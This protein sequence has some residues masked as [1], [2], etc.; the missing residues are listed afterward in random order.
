M[1]VNGRR[2][3]LD[4]VSLKPMFKFDG[5][6]L[7]AF[8]KRQ[9]Q[10]V[11]DAFRTVSAVKNILFNQELSSLFSN[12]ERNKQTEFHCHEDANSLPKG[13][14]FEGLRSVGASWKNVQ[15]GEIDF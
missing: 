12:I 9:R 3:S 7:V 8:H 14:S 1:G 13:K 10:F 2:R 5:V 15:Y 6:N 4:L 11:L